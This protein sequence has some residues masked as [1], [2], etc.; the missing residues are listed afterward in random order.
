[1]IKD[2]KEIYNRVSGKAPIPL[3][4]INPVHDYSFK[5]L[6]KAEAMG[7]IKPFI[8]KNE[9]PTVA[10][11]N[12]VASMENDKPWLL[13][14][15]DIDTASMLKAVIDSDLRISEKRMLSHVA[16]I[17]SPYYNRLILTTDG[18]VNTKLNE[19]IVA[20]LIE[21]ALTVTNILRNQQ[22]N[23]AALSLIES[24]SA[25]IP[26]TIMADE[27]F[28]NHNSDPRF[29][30]EGPIALD[31]ALSQQA[32]TSKGISSKIA[33]KTDVFIGPSITTT[34]FIGKALLS[35]GNARGGGIVL[36]ATVPIVLLSRSDTLETK[37]NSIALGL[38][39]L[40]GEKN[41]Y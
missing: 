16:V 3:A 1:M 21:N 22:P 25:K 24:V 11:R 18:G 39:I 4:I 35:V 13:M 28:K 5:A 10:V 31:V 19:V 7:W 30:I 23:F 37:L 40:Q 34:N 15:G 26:N 36:G 8:F 41:G 9:V 29:T 6:E 32:A 2:Y 38:L 27:I 17:E 20:S 33:G 12:A 14:K